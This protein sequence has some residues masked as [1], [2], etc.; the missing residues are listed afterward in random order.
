M[1]MG[2]IL[3]HFSQAVDLKRKAAVRCWFFTP[4]CTDSAC[5]YSFI[6][7]ETSIRKTA[8]AIAPRFATLA[9]TRD[10]NGLGTQIAT[11]LL[12]V[13]AIYQCVYTCIC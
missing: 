10:G 4:L 11:Y 5:A 7:S 2:Q 3:A 13:N 9:Q 6:C 1:K 12:R 8:G